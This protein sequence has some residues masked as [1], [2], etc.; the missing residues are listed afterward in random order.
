MTEALT[1]A[2]V[3]DVGRD[4]KHL[5]FRV[6]YGSSGSW[7]DADIWLDPDTSRYFA[8]TREAAQFM[9]AI[10]LVKDLDEE[11]QEKTWCQA[12]DVAREI[13]LRGGPPPGAIDLTGEI[14]TV[15]PVPSFRPA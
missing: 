2:E 13:V 11:S 6:V 8:L 9:C 5:G 14:D 3:E 15:G 7:A 10:E 1:R 12:R 4:L